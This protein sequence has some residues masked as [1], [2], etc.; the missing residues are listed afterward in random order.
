MEAYDFRTGV[1]RP[2][3]CVT[4]G[5]ELIK[6]DYWL[7]FA[8][9][10]VG[11][12]IGGATLYILLGAMACGIFFCYLRAIDGKPVSFDG[13]WK[14]FEWFVPGLVVTAFI[15]V[16]IIVL[17]AIIYAPFIV[18]FA[19]GL[20]PND[21]AF[22][23][24]IA[25]A[26]AI[27]LVMM[28]AMVCFHTLLMFSFPLIVDRGESGIGSIKLSAKAVW[29]NLGGVAG[30]VGV[31]FLLTPAGYAALCI[32]VYFAVPVMIASTAVAYRRIFPRR[33]ADSSMPPPP[34]SFF[35]DVPNHAR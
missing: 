13:L 31:N 20:E 2:W 33:D 7:L 14:G 32:G 16:P 8:I 10:L 22:F 24:L 28:V 26:L 21:P 18:A 34:P 23:P 1:I 35:Q 30:L 27:D 19:A 29:Q 17:Y 15:V 6:R 9:A 5:F 12:V 11:L 4:E 3:E 25:G